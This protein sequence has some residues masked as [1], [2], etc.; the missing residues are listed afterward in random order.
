MQTGWSSLTQLQSSVESLLAQGGV[1][2]WHWGMHPM[3]WG[4]GLGM[5]LMMLL[6]WG[7]MIGGL[8]LAIRWLLDQRKNTRAVTAL[9]ILKRR[10][11]EGEIE[12]EEFEAMRQDLS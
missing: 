2:E 10:Y 7:L 4:W 8:V 6:F 9:E 12:K 3:W 5:M 1:Y 11:A